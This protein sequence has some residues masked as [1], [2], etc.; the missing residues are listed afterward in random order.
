VFSEVEFDALLSSVDRSGHWGT[1]DQDGALNFIT[2]AVRTAALAAVTCD[3][4]VSCARPILTLEA[5]T[6]PVGLT[7][8]VDAMSGQQWSAVNEHLT[9]QGHGR[10]GTTHLDAL[11]HFA[12]KGRTYNQRPQVPAAEEQMLDIRAVARGVLTRGFLVDLPAA[13]DQGLLEP[14]AP[15]SLSLLQQLLHRTGVTVRSGDALAL[16]MNVGTSGCIGGLS[17]DCAAWLHDREICLVVTDGGFET[18]PS[19]VENVIV[20]WHVL[21]L[22]A[23]G[24]HLIDLAELDALSAT[25]VRR[26][27]W[28]FLLTLA[29]PPITGSTSALIN[30]LAIF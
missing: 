26:A 12:W 11:A 30:P 21:A 6:G 29:P 24:L 9:V 14:G 16:R 4:V 5:G 20:P 28:T 3:A 1:G 13:V 2:P 22:T 15:C 7:R 27:R 17:L 10:D 23:M 18:E 25:C 19:Q 8:T